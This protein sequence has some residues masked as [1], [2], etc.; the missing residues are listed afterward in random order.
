MGNVTLAQSSSLLQ[1]M[2]PHLCKVGKC[3][4]HRMVLFICLSVMCLYIIVNLKHSTD[5]ARIGVS[6]K[7]QRWGGVTIKFG[8]VDDSSSGDVDI[9]KICNSL[10]SYIF[11]ISLLCTSRI[12]VLYY[13]FNLS[14]ESR[15]LISHLSP[16]DSVHSCFSNPQA[17]RKFLKNV[18]L[19]DS[20]PKKTLDF[21]LGRSQI[22][23]RR[24]T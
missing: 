14:W 3:S 4:G 16:V 18:H 17:S 8:C 6:T 22:H 23:Q 10:S 1:S 2:V 20:H 9:T 12:P 13:S 24:S 15:L 11:I 19:S 7:C 21:S 5:S